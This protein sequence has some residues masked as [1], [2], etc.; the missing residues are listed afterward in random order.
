MRA[1]ADTPAGSARTDE[2]TGSW[3]PRGCLLDG[4]VDR[5]DQAAGVD[6]ADLE[7]LTRLDVRTR[8]T[9]YQIIVTGPRRSEVLIQGGRFFPELTEA[10]LLGATIGGS[11][12]KM[13]WLGR[14]LS[15]EI[16]ARGQRIVTSPVQTIEFRKD[17]T[18][19]GPF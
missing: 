18:L 15:M 4:F 19:P 8:N 1:V 7:P 14:G 2:Q 17:S 6:V 9:W 5:L 11:F 13:D 16:S 10:R 12:L 3:L